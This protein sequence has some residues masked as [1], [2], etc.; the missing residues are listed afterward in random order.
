MMRELGIEVS[1][2]GVATLL[3]RFIDGLVIDTADAVLAPR[4][5]ELGLQVLCSQTV[6]YDDT[7]RQRL[8]EQVLHFAGGLAVTA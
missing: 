8:A 5:R 6:M 2:F 3:R 4:I 1:A 7:D